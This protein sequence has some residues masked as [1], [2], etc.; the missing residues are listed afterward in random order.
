M[1]H[2]RKQPSQKYIEAEIL[3]HLQL[4]HELST[5]SFDE[6]EN[7]LLKIAYKQMRIQDTETNQGQGSISSQLDK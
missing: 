3:P 4:Q 6:G 5:L 1:L 2:Y 7:K